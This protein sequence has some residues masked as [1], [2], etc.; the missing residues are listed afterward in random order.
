MQSWVLFYV[1]RCC[2]KTAVE[3]FQLRYWHTSKNTKEAAPLSNLWGKSSTQWHGFYTFIKELTTKLWITLTNQIL[4]LT[5]CC[6]GLRSSKEYCQ[7]K[8]SHFLGKRR[9]KK[10][11]PTTD[12]E[13]IVDFSQEQ[14]HLARQH[15]RNIR[16]REEDKSDSNLAPKRK[17]PRTTLFQR[18]TL[19]Q[20]SHGTNQQ[21]DIHHLR[22]KQAHLPQD[23][24][25]ELLQEDGM[26]H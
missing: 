21:Q 5:I 11:I 19:T 14:Y 9:K 20:S 25:P 18:S 10:P 26:Y 3:L 12:A 1:L 4:C 15:Q 8:G 2:N 13:A 7:R 23:K 17:R 16:S 24:T 22:E 6:S